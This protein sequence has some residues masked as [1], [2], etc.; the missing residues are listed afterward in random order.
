MKLLFPFIN[1]KKKKEH[2]ILPDIFISF[3][4]DI[5][6]RGDPPHKYNPTRIIVPIHLLNPPKQPISINKLLLCLVEKRATQILF[7][8]IEFGALQSSD[9]SNPA[10][11]DLP[12]L[13]ISSPV[14][15]HGEKQE[16]RS[17]REREEKRNKRASSNPL[18]L[19]AKNKDLPW[20]TPT[21]NDF[22]SKS[23]NRWI[24]GHPAVW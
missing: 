23:P 20:A 5:K 17:S 11:V 4:H 9:S 21:P 14:V 19:L 22:F 3:F 7:L 13:S 1:R 8:A 24:R 18:H 16:R 6:L 12:T 10:N 2:F 15:V